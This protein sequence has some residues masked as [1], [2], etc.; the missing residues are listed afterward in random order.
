MLEHNFNVPDGTLV[1]PRRKV[2]VLDVQVIM[3]RLEV[4]GKD[5][6]VRHGCVSSH[7]VSVDCNC[8]E[9]TVATEPKGCSSADFKWTVV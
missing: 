3:R 6:S 7:C 8:I 2:Q 5:I 9:R 4:V 1:R